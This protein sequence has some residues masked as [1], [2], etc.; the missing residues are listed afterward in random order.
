MSRNIGPSPGAAR[1]PQHNV[2]IRPDSARWKAVLNDELLADSVDVLLLEESGFQPVIYF[3]P[4]DVRTTGLQQSDSR[5]TCPFKGEAAY[6]QASL[7]GDWVDVAWYYR[8]VYREVE[9][10]AGYVAFYADRVS[11]SPEQSHGE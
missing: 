10:I 8:E 1:H 4:G 9:P 5:T 2:T 6:W 3:P 11:V 7:D